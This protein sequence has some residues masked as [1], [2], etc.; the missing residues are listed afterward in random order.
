MEAHFSHERKV[1]HEG[2]NDV[3][4]P[5]EGLSICSFLVLDLYWFSLKSGD[6]WFKS[7]RLKKTIWSDFQARFNHGKEV[8]HEEVEDDF[9]HSKVS[10]RRIKSP[11]SVPG[12][13]MQ[14]LILY[15]LGFN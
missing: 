12:F 9:A 3:F 14:T 6:V 1:G 5:T 2:V 4:A 7:R 15:K 11:S 13:H 10:Q 8:G